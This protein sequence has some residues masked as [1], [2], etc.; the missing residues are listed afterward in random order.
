MNSPAIEL[1]SATAVRGGRPIWSDADLS[2]PE[3]AFTAVIG[4]NGSGKSTL[5]EVILGLVPLGAGSASV[6]GRPV[7]RGNP[8]IGLVPQR[9]ALANATEIRCRD[10]VRAGAT[11]TRWG[12][13]LRSG[14]DATDRALA[15]VGAAEWADERL[16]L[17]SGGQQQRVSIAAA[18]V[19]QP[20]LLILD[21]PLTGLDLAGQV[22]LVE[23]VH[24][25]NRRDGV[26][27]LFITHDLN[28]VLDHIDSAVFLTGGRAHF[29]PVDEVIEPDLLSR[30]Y[31]T[32]VQVS[33]TADGCVFTRAE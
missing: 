20:G 4:P 25:I 14:R 21:E 27:V 22:D 16:G 7:R 5:A 19:A 10:L 30:I 17:L 2:V 18:L 28:P 3:G 31:G 8:A 11:G 26:T 12:I 15:A 13:G 23:L 6:F 24:G 32:P 1:C 33:R 29:A 9:R